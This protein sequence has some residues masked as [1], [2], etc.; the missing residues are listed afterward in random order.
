[1]MTTVVTTSSM[2]NLSQE[3]KR[4]YLFGMKGVLKSIFFDNSEKIIADT[5]KLSEKF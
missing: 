3:L 1:M 4:K 2:D 5:A